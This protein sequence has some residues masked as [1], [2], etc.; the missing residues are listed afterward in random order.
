MQH[1]HAR[2]LVNYWDSR[3]RQSPVPARAD[4]AAADLRDLLGNLFMLQ[5][6]DASHH[7]FRLAGTQVC[8][9]HQRELREQNFLS[10]W[11]GYDREHMK[12]L[13]ES[14]LAF[15]APGSAVATAHSLSGDRMEVEMVF[16]PLASKAGSVDR[17]LG[18]YQP[19]QSPETFRRR[20]VVRHDLD[21]VSLPAKR[22][23]THAS[24]RPPRVL[25]AAN[26]R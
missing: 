1:A 16:T 3:R 9:L 19:L 5:R 22:L 10:F 20:P 11:R 2:T 17:V 15:A 23:W 26:D 18:L 14:V 8:H 4:I 6:H 13:L 21:R 7:V 12:L 24:G 25:N